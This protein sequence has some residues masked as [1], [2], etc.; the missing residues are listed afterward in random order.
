MGVVTLVR[1]GQASFGADNYD[2]LSTL[3]IEQ[4]RVLGQSLKTQGEHIPVLVHGDLVRHRESVEALQLGY[5]QKVP[6]EEL[7][8]WNEFDHR[9]VIRQYVLTHP[10]SLP[11][12]MSKD[13][14]RVLP[15][16]I[17]AVERWQER[18]DDVQYPETWEMFCRR[19][20]QG[21]LH[22]YRLMDTYSDIWVLTSG[23]PIALSVM[24]TL[25][26]GPEQMVQLNRRLVNTG[27]TR[28]L[29]QATERELLTLNEHRHLSGTN[30]H[31]RTYR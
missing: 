24:T 11:D 5:G 15:I 14:D 23:G 20:E 17:K 31:L 29:C 28:F 25:K 22:L 4:A 19:I 2:K 9:E 16:F 30:Q 18:A 12:V 27:V 26:T 10:M 21:W 3:G 8:E 13:P 6:C 7:P 1:H